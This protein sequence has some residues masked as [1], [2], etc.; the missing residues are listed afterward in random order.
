MYF[1]EQV[2]RWL[3]ESAARR[4]S[5]D[6]SQHVLCMHHGAIASGAIHASVTACTRNLTEAL[7]SREIAR[8][9]IVPAPLHIDPRGRR[10]A[11]TWWIQPFGPD[12]E[13]NTWVT[14]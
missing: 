7:T 11:S 13:D 8:G 5:W 1:L 4:P 14:E 9:I 2:Y 3:A 12:A 6:T 10:F